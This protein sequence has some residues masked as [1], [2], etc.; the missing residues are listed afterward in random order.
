MANEWREVLLEDVAADLTVGHVGPMASEYVEQGIPFLRSQNVEAL[1]INDTDLKFI[2]EEFHGRLKKSALSPGDVVIVRTGKPGACAVIPQTL[3]VSNCSDLVVVRCG[4]ELDPRFFAYYVNSVAVHHVNSH[5]VGAVQ[6]HFNVGSARKMIVLL[7]DLDEQRAIAG[8]L[9]TLDDKIEL[10]RRMSETLEA[11]ARALF[12]SWFVDFDPVRAKAKGRDPGLPDDLAALFPDCFSGSS[13]CAV[14]AGW[15]PC[16][17]GD[18]ISLEYGK[19]LRSYR[20]GRFPVYGTNGKI[21]YHDQPICNH[22]SIIVGRKGAYRGIHFSA[23]PPFVIDT[24]FFVEPR[25]S[26]EIRWAYYEMLRIRLDE[27]DSGSAVPST[28]RSQ[29]LSLPVLFPPLPTQA[30]FMQLG[31]PLWQ[32][33]V[34]LEDETGTLMELR[35]ALLPQLLSGELRIRDVLGFASSQ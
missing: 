15:T 5:L 2:T 3:P 8:I 32:R 19:A 4:P 25:C 17:W 1:R 7:P 24:A 31:Y 34:A 28:D 26:L 13:V 20:P 33:R 16:A 22:P 21:G 27:M 23:T 12:K 35:D 18:L 14:P 29:F 30:A 9:G 11:M 6:Q 10:N